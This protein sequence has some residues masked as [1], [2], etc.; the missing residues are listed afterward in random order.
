ML[1][2]PLE[3]WIR[4]LVWFVIGIVIY[5]SYGVRNSKLAQP[6]AAPASQPQAK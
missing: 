3:T 1:F 4:L 5:F 2:L 6:A